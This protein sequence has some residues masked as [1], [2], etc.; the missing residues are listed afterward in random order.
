MIKGN[1]KK[2]TLLKICGITRPQDLVVCH[3]LSVD[4]IGFNFYKKSKRYIDPKQASVLWQAFVKQIP[5][6]KLIPVLVCVDAEAS[7]LKLW[8]SLFPSNV[9]FQ[10]H[11]KET[12]EHLSQSL[13]LTKR[14]IWKAISVQ[15][16]VVRD[17]VK[18]FQVCARR[19]LLD[20]PVV[21]VGGD[22][23]GGSGTTFQWN[24]YADLISQSNIGVAGG[25]SPDN[26]DELLRY[27][28]S[29]VDVASGAESAPGIKDSAKIQ[30]L[31]SACRK[32]VI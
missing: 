5:T 31:V 9:I 7:D 14:E 13:T 11:G 20:S 27:K 10:M 1:S 6:S 32:A 19:I 2:T 24:D 29:L 12:P 16:E 30:R 23:A 21:P 25:V 26:I 17:E 4:L 15:S 28:P 22:A 3:N 18:N 8:S